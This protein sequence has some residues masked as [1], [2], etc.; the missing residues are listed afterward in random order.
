MSIEEQSLYW[1]VNK[2]LIRGKILLER[3]ESLKSNC[4]DERCGIVFNSLCEL[5]KELKTGNNSL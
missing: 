5:V 1:D 3:L 2:N 4:N